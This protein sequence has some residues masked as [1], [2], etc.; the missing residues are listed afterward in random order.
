MALQTIDDKDIFSPLPSG[1]SQQE[2]IS[3]MLNLSVQSQ[4]VCKPLFEQIRQECNCIIEDDL[5]TAE[6]IAEKIVRPSILKSR[7]WFD[8]EHLQDAYRFM[9]VFA[10][11]DVLSKMADQFSKSGFELVRKNFMG[12][13]EGNTYGWRSAA[14][15]FRVPET[16]QIAEYLLVPL[17]IETVKSEGHAL[18]SQLRYEDYTKLKDE[19][20][21]EYFQ[22]KLQ[23]RTLYNNAWNSFLHR[24]NIDEDALKTLLNKLQD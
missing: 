12:L 21:K 13:S 23:S 10:S 19:H 9:T 16:K 4:L 22:L 3:A 2:K 8:V 6:S 7:P 17:E 5:K 20:R 1:L 24:N 18:Y 11:I 14:L 15:I